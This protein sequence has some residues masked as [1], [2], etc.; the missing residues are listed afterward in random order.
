[1]AVQDIRSDL[2]AQFMGT[3]TNQGDGTGNFA[4]T[5][6]GADYELGVEFFIHVTGIDATAVVTANVRTS[7]FAD[8]S[9]NVTTLVPADEEFIGSGIVDVT[10]VTASPIAAGTPTSEPGDGTRTR[11]ESRMS[12]FGIIANPRYM[13]VDVVVTGAAGATM[14][15]NCFAMQKAEDMPVATPSEATGNSDLPPLP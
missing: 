15:L 14:D 8:F 12:T 2:I 1:M 5:L 7:D 10:V 13:E 4:G 11:T 3:L 6:D 9:S